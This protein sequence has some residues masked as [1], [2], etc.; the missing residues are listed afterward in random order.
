MSKIQGQV[1]LVTGANRGI[2]KALV[3]EL[4]ALGAAKIYAAAR[5]PEKLDAVVQAGDGKIVPVKLEVTDEKAVKALGEELQDVSLL[6]NNAGIARF[7]GLVAADGIQDARDEMEVNY[8]APLNLTRAFAPVLKKNGGGAV[9]NLSSIAGQVNFPA[10][11]SYSASKAAVHSLTQGVRA[12]LAAQGT[13]VSGVYPGPIDTD[14]A[15]G[16]EMDKATANDTARAILTE[17]DQGVE[18]IYPDPMSQQ[19]HGG[20]L[21]DPKA[22]EAQTAEMLPE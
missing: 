17:M 5:S 19:M 13:R 21:S 14:M 11:G 10:L 9:I 22:V 1:A 7:Q 12:E 4:L 16:L 18:D 6:V 20:L 8:F 15:A 3:E 2:G